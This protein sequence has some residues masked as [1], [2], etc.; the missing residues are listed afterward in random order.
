MRQDRQLYHSIHGILSQC[1]RGGLNLR[2]R[3]W[4]EDMKF[5]ALCWHAWPKVGNWPQWLHSSATPSRNLWYGGT[6]RQVH[7]QSPC[8]LVSCS[9]CME[10][11]PFVTSRWSPIILPTNLSKCVPEA[12]V[13]ESERN[14]TKSSPKNSVG[15]WGLGQAGHRVLNG[16]L[17]DAA[18]T[19]CE[20]MLLCARV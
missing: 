15:L 18:E 19:F 3:P 1:G 9:L 16:R 7:H 11:P 20:M 8:L 12:A 6:I 2:H 4:L 5:W 17:E 14:A 13:R 10:V